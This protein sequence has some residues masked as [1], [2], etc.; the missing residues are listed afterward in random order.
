MLP[1]GNDAALAIGRHIAGSDS[2]FVS[3]MN[4]LLERQ[5]LHE[6]HFLNPHGL[7]GGNHVTSAYDLA[8]L[9]RYGMSLP[10]FKEIVNTTHY[11]AKGNREIPLNNVN[12]FLGYKGADGVKTGYTRGAGST[13]AASMTRDGHRLYAIVLNAPSRD[14]DASK[15]LNWAFG[16]FGWPPAQ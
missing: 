8:M 6:S 2:D 1:S 16:N 5:G 10:G 13:L 15:L 12:T 9:S 7:G 11:V 3:R 14:Y 4:E